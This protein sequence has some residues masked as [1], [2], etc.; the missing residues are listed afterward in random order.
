MV[1]VCF[2]DAVLLLI[3]CYN[4]WCFWKRSFFEPCFRLLQDAVKCFL[5]FPYHQ[6]VLQSSCSW[7]PL[8]SMGG[9]DIV[10]SPWIARLLKRIWVMTCSSSDNCTVGEIS[11]SRTG[12]GKWS[13]VKVNRPRHF[14]RWYLDMVVPILNC[15]HQFRV[16]W[17]DARD[18]DANIKQDT[19]SET[20]KHMEVWQYG[21]VDTCNYLQLISYSPHYE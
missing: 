12:L 1:K 10:E 13:M 19:D 20:A 21:T 5:G 4:F 8:V 15:L 2:F 16:S 3:I 11:L 6:I 14:T 18:A 17:K 7:S 9:F